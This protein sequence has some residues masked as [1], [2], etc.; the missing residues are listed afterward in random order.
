MMRVFW[1]KITAA[2]G[3]PSLTVRDF[4]NGPRDGD[5]NKM[6]FWWPYIDCWNEECQR[7][8]LYNLNDDPTESN[9]LAF[10]PEYKERLD[11][12]MIRLTEKL[13]K[14]YEAGEIESDRSVEGIG[15]QILSMQKRLRIII[16]IIAITVA[17]ILILLCRVCYVCC[18][19]CSC[20]SGH[21]K[22]KV[23]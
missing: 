11:D 21:K 17:V 9:N 15:A 14:E 10:K 12:I 20:K 19:C 7:V 3:C 16:M 8:R 6:T 22:T 2:K 1:I 23:Q 13:K 18:V 4:M 5:G